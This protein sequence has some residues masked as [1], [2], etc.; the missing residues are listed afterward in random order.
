MPFDPKTSGYSSFLFMKKNSFCIIKISLKLSKNLS[1]IKIKTLM[2]FFTED[3][4]LNF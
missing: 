1:V 3:I 4:Y 2:L